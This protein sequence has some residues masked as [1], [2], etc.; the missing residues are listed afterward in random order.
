MSNSHSFILQIQQ[1]NGEW[2]D[3]TEHSCA[4]NALKH[5]E[6]IEAI[7]RVNARI[8]LV[9][10]QVEIDSYLHFDTKGICHDKARIED[11]NQVSKK[12]NNKKIELFDMH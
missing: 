3:N 1:P 9:S 11:L 10:S 2:W 5:K 12:I 6:A 4:I 8:L 7:H